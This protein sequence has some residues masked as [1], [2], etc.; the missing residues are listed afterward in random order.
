MASRARVRASGD[1]PADE[2]AKEL[3][4]ELDAD[5][6]TVPIETIF[7]R[8]MPSDGARIVASLNRCCAS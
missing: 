4:A 7:S 1:T 6:I 5:A 2:T 8:M 3:V